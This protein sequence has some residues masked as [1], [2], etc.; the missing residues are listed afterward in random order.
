[1]ANSNLAELPFDEAAA[2]PIRLADCNVAGPMVDLDKLA[3]IAKD[4]IAELADD[5][6][7]EQVA[8]WAGE[9]DEELSGALAGDP[10]YNS[11]V[12]AIRNAAVKNIR[13]DLAKWSDFRSAYGF[14]YPTI[15]EPISDPT[16][17]RVGGMDP[18]LARQ[19]AADFVAHYNHD[20]DRDVWFEQ[21]R[22]LAAR[23]DFAANKTQLN[24]EPDRY[25][26][27]LRDVATLVRVLVTGASQ[28]PDL[29]SVAMVLG[30]DEVTRR[31]SALADRSG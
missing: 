4:Y 20:P 13:K 12:L 28:S 19:V 22:E 18:G 8:N 23:N 25:H 5:E 26:G 15:F 7:I 29:F 9:N 1:L 31:V 24:E 10:A 2:K 14:L 16:D 17:E 11:S 6:V 21:I 3:D 27:L 30:A